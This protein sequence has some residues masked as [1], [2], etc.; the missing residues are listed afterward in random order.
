VTGHRTYPSGTAAAVELLERSLSYTRAGL[1]LCPSADPDARTP[2]AEWDLSALL[3]HMEESLD[4]IIELA[5]GTLALVPA[6]PAG[7]LAGRVQRLQL[8]ACEMLATWSGE[9]PAAVDGSVLVHNRVA[10]TPLLLTASA[11]EIAV[12]GW[13]VHRA[14]GSDQPIP[15]S[16]A[17]ALLP[18][19]PHVVDPRHFA[20]PRPSH[21]D[22]GA[23]NALLGLVGR[24]GLVL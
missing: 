4:A 20:S 6:T 17:R 19:V 7:G 15:D 11:L 18:V 2:C 1:V 16:L 22:T 21:P 12:H 5:T 24:S 13:D 14:V 3:T 10:P 8:K 9:T 23:A